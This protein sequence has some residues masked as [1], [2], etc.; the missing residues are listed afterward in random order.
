MPPAGREK[1]SIL[2][3]AMEAVLGAVYLDGGKEVAF[4]ARRAAVLG[5]DSRRPCRRSTGSTTSRRCRSWRR[6]ATFA[7][8][9]YSVQSTGP[10][11]DKRFFAGVTVAKQVVGEGDGRSKKSAEQAAAAAAFARPHGQLMPELPE[12]E[13]VRRGLERFVVGRRINRVEVGRERRCGAPRGRP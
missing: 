6:T 2:S 3:D 10:D 13:T 5:R 12:V 4:D 11:H 7:G 8:P 1:V 9:D